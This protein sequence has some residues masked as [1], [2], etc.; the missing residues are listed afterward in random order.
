[1][2]AA[3]HGAMAVP[4]RVM[5]EALASMDVCR[6]MAEQGN[7]ASVSDAGVGALCARAAVLGAGLNVRI[8][9][10]GLKDKA[11]VDA[12]LK[13]T[14]EIERTAMA[15]EAEILRIVRGRMSG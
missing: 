9:A 4:L 13:R 10:P 6:A 8:N 11:A 14:D 7:P 1:M 5:E 15:Q 2:Q 12:M 3:T